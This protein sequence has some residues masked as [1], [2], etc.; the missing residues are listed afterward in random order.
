MSVHVPNIRD[1]GK[2]Y[3]EFCVLFSVDRSNNKT[4]LRKVLLNF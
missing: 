2:D 1:L 4:I 3:P